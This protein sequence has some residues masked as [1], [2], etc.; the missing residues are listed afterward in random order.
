MIEGHTGTKLNS[1][2]ERKKKGLK[3]RESEAPKNSYLHKAMQKSQAEKI[4][5]VKLLASQKRILAMIL[6]LGALMGAYYLIYGQKKLSIVAALEQLGVIKQKALPTSPV[7]LKAKKP[8]STQS[9]ISAKL[10][11]PPIKELSQN[12][13]LSIVEAEKKEPAVIEH[14]LDAVFTEET[15]LRI[16]IDDQVKHEYLFKPGDSIT[17]R[18]KKGFKLRIGNAGGLKLILNG[19]PLPSPGLHGQVKNLTL[20]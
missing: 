14:T 7:V 12:K 9:Q 16:L 10:Q 4:R 18:A 20:P 17:W 19:K 6:I 3:M 5:S 15:W 13:P 11:K 1:E 2:F 8:V